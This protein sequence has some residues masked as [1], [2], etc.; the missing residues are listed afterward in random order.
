MKLKHK[1][2]MYQQKDKYHNHHILTKKVNYAKHLLQSLSLKTLETSSQE[3]NLDSQKD[4][5][6]HMLQKM[7]EDTNHKAY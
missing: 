3:L 6:H 5:M 7:K 2:L 1:N 4:H